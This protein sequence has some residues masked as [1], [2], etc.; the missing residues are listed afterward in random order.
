MCIPYLETLANK[1]KKKRP[2]VV[3]L[4][5]ILTKKSGFSDRKKDFFMDLI[6][7]K[8]K[9][10]LNNYA[11][12]LGTLDWDYFCTFTTGYELTLKSAR[13]AM[14]RFHNKIA[15]NYGGSILFWVAEPYECKDGFH[16]HALLKLKNETLTNEVR[17]KVK[18][19][20]SNGKIV[21]FVIQET[22]F[23]VVK[24]T[25]QL[26]TKAHEK[27]YNRIELKRYNK[28]L[29]AKH[30]VGKYILKTRSDY[31]ILI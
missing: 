17:R 23:N 18:T 2:I 21:D 10:I 15:Q 31:D 25:W 7:H 4:L 22:G 30:Y 3:G 11:N 8:D 13:R 27:N 29:G 16:T 9:H 14:Q 20:L 19:T 12:F 26:V 24:D 5:K 28:K 6:M 1:E